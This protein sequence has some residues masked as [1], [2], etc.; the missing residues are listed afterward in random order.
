MDQPSSASQTLPFRPRRPVPHVCIA[1]DKPHVRTF[2]A[3]LLDELGFVSHECDTRAVADT[4]AAFAPDLLVLG[5]PPEQSKA[6]AVLRHLASHDFHGRVMLFGG[7][8][9]PALPAIHELAETLGLA[10]LPPLGTPFRSSDLTENLADFLPVRAPLPAEIDVED[11]LRHG[12]LELRYQ[13]KIDPHLLTLRG[14][15]AL[16]RMRHPVL[17]IVPP[18][19]FIP[20]SDDPNFRALSEFVVA[21][22]VAD[23]AGFAAN[24]TPVEISINLP[25]ALLANQSFIDSL[26]RQLP[27][28][29]AFSGLIVEVKSGDVIGN[30]ALACAVARQIGT[31]NVR[32]AID[33]I[34]T[35]GP[36]LGKMDSCP[37]TELKVDWRRMASA[38][39]ERRQALCGPVIDLARRFGASSVAVGIE[40]PADFDA[41]RDLGFSLVQGFLFA[42][43]LEVRKFARTMLSR[44]GAAFT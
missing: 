19:S 8:S 11:A 13:P 27:N 12:W 18:A 24:N 15:E 25:L 23:W 37:F 20:G 38:T 30:L 16:I 39:E 2:L 34:G 7:R 40:T 9:S 17:G 26:R 5:I 3:D 41:A 6:T 43:P 10:M 14:A 36:Q 35:E 32:V 22:A 4:I 31:Y 21:R 29:P 44:R 28:H 42:E 1:D 33:D